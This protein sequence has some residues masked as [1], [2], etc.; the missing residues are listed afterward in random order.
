MTGKLIRIL[1]CMTLG[2]AATQASAQTRL[3]GVEYGLLSLSDQRT[4]AALAMIA[5]HG[6]DGTSALQ[7]LADTLI[8]GQKSSWGQRRVAA[9]RF[10]DPGPNVVLPQAF[11]S[12]PQ[13]RLGFSL[14]F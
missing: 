3:F 10:R 14:R 5:N 6:E 8:F 11:R 1:V 4:S 13:V 12:P 2:L 9:Y 7:A